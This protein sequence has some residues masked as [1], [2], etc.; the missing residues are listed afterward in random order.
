MNES[1]VAEKVLFDSKKIQ[2]QDKKSIPSSTMW[3]EDSPKASTLAC[4]D[5]VTS[6]K[7]LS[8]PQGSGAATPK[9]V[10]KASDDQDPI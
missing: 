10:Q 5:P 2:I 4:M 3:S 9:F 6:I 7:P 1:H 8:A